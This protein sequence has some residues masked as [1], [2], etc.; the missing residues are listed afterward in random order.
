VLVLFAD[1]ERLERWRDRIEAIRARALGGVPA[2]AMT[3]RRPARR[4]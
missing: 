4:T 3:A 1:E 2:D